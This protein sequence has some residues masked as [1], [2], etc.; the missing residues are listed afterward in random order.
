V[1]NTVENNIFVDGQRGQIQWNPWRDRVMTG[2][3]CERN[4]V[5][6]QGPGSNAYTLNGFEDEF[7]TFRSNLVWAG[8]KTPT[9]TG[10][11]GLPRRRSWEG[12]LARGQDAGALVADP[13][14]VDPEN[15]DYRLKPTSPAFD[16]GFEAIDLSTVGNYESPDR[17]T[18]PRPEVPVVR[19]AT[20]YSPEVSSDSQPVLRDY[21]DSPIGDTEHNAHVG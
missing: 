3:R 18:W 15:R 12:W 14:F 10:L 11:S 17:Y 20:D 16:L 6:Y 1:D 19:D 21:E 7:V 9:I 5:A 8:G 4:I 2:H 13:Q